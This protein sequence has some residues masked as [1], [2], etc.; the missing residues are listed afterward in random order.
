MKDDDIFGDEDFFLIR[1]NQT[2]SQ[3]CEDE[4][5]CVFSFLGDSLMINMNIEHF[6]IG[7]QRRYSFSMYTRPYWNPIRSS[8]RRPHIIH[9]SQAQ[10]KLVFARGCVITTLRIWIYVSLFIWLGIYNLSFV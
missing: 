10:R 5:G 8:Y 7:L 6:L 2:I 3:N 1:L 9:T 4:H